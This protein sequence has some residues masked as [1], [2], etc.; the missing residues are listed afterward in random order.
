MVCHTTNHNIAQEVRQSWHTSDEMCFD[1]P[2]K[3]LHAIHMFN[4]PHPDR[5]LHCFLSV[6]EMVFRLRLK[7][8]SPD[9]IISLA[10]VY[11]ERET[12]RKTVGPKTVNLEL[13]AGWLLSC[14]L[15]PSGSVFNLHPLCPMSNSPSITLVL[16][17]SSINTADIHGLPQM[18]YCQTIPAIFLSK[19]YQE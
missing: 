8:L 7:R 10:Q 14:Q 15:S 9:Y 11:I 12:D 3:A 2:L 18:P 6:N 19:I 4:T 5:F 13:S 16:L 1:I 17:R